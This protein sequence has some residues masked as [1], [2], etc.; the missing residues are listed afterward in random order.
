[1]FLCCVWALVS[2]LPSMMCFCFGTFGAEYVVCGVAP[3]GPPPTKGRV[4]V[5]V[6]A[7]CCCLDLPQDYLDPNRYVEGSYGLF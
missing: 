5:W 6:L 2:E 7:V 4:V 3:A 1:M